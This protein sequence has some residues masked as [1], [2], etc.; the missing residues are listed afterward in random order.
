VSRK[1]Y[2]RIVEDAVRHACV[3]RPLL[4][5]GFKEYAEGSEVVRSR[6]SLSASSRSTSSSTQSKKKQ[7]AG[8][9]NFSWG[10]IKIDDF[11]LVKWYQ[12]V[13][14]FPGIRSSGFFSLDWDIEAA[15]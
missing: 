6:S 9:W 4:L 15:L 11:A 14:H 13:N 5:A 10:H 1:V 7:S 2:F 8:T 12:K 3:V